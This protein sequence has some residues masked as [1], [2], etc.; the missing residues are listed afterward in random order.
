MRTV[1][2]DELCTGL[3]VYYHYAQF[4]PDGPFTVKSFFSNYQGRHVILSRNEHQDRD[5]LLADDDDFGKLLFYT[6]T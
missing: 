6:E 4:S 5:V 2:H 3:E 1:E